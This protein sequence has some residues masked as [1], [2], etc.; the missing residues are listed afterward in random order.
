MRLS[1]V[2]LHQQPGRFVQV[3]PG[4]TR[5]AMLGV[6]LFDA[7]GNV[8]D[9]LSL[10]A[11]IA[12]ELG[13]TQGGGSTPWRLVTDVP[14]NVQ[15]LASLSGSGLVTRTGAGA[16]V[17]RSVAVASTDRL[18]VANPAGDSGDIT[19]DLATVPNSGVGALLKFAHDGYGRVTG[20]SAVTADDLEPLISGGVIPV[21]TGEI[22][23]VLVYGPDGSL[24]YIGV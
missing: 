16:I 19:I 3:E 21:V 20:S 12:T 8:L 5:G 22:P 2:P 23:P 18:T 6:N 17:A 10:A 11:L 14:P 1:R 7:S 4:A 13:A 9:A 24:I 15:G